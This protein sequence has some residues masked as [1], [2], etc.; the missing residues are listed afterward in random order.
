MNGGASAN[1]A[2]N[3]CVLYNNFST[4]RGGGTFGAYL[5]NCTV[6]GNSATSQGG[7]TWGGAIYNSIVYYNS[8]PTDSN[9]ST[10]PIF[11]SCTTKTTG[12]GITNEPAFVDLVAGDLRLS[13]NSPCIN[14][15]N[16]A[17][18]TNATDL[19]GDA[20]ITAGTVD[21]GAF[22]FPSPGSIVSYAWLQQYSLPA[23][24]SADYVDSDGDGMNNWQEWRAGTVPTN[25]LSRLAM[26]AATPGPSGVTVQWQSVGGKF[27]SLQRATSLGFASPSLVTV[28]SN[29]FGNAGTTS[30]L[31]SSAPNSESLFYRVGV[32]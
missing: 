10:G 15:G 22:E 8:A 16:S 27:Y 2:M 5:T 13:S 24:G 11:Y 4:N 32:Q 3:N 20:R 21:I 17:Y 28:F 31:D 25:A 6:V 23:D 9:A 19:A 12:T 14:A 26:V 1:S 7:G 18:I 29:I 30:Y